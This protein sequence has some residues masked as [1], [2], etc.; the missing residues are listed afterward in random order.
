MG[1]E[2]SLF[3]KKQILNAKE[4]FYVEYKKDIYGRILAFI[5]VDNTLLPVKIIENGLG[6]ETVSKY[7]NEYPLD[8]KNIFS[9]WD[10][11]ILEASLKVGKPNFENPFYW[12]AKNK[13]LKNK[14]KRQNKKRK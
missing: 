14:I 11:E 9:S 4:L 10:Q 2:A 5:F 8:D 12:R 13:K 3:T 7:K 6:Y 1:K